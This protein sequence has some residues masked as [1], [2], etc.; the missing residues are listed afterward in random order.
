MSDVVVAK[1]YADALF[2]LG[3]E[4]QKLEQFVDELKVVQPVFQ[5]DKKLAK[6]L[7]HPKFDNAKKK[8]LVVDAFK[9]LDKPILNTLQ[10]LIDRHRISIIP[11]I[12]DE[13]ISLVN[14]AKGMA[15][16]TV[17]STR[18]LSDDE[19]KHLERSFA[20]RLG[21]NAV[22]LTNIVDPAIL[23]GIK[24]RVGNTIYDGTV[25]GKLDRISRSIVSAN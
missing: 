4:Q 1:R 16:A 23:G 10:L 2:S 15:D 19:K 8:E 22:Q 24:I 17:Y 13:F 9:G 11:T 18:K 12:I 7:A 3:L 21:K 6:F 20:V 5:N 14:D 25:K